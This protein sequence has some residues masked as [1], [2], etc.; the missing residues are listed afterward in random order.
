MK[1]TPEELWRVTKYVELLTVIDHK[2]NR[3]KRL[4]LRRLLTVLN[5]II[6][7]RK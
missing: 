7:Q 4:Q 5:R 3:E 1:L 6:R 2:V